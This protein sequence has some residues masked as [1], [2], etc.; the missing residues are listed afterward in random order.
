MKWTEINYER[1]ICENPDIAF[2][3]AILENPILTFR[4][5]NR[6]VYTKGNVCK[7]TK[8]HKL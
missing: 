7:G 4:M 5:E 6:L 3:L 2:V 8:N 1:A